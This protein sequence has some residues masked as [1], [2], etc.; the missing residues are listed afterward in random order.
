MNVCFVQGDQSSTFVPKFKRHVCCAQERQLYTN[1]T[2][3]EET[4][5]TKSFSPDGHRQLLTTAST[6]TTPGKH[7]ANTCSSVTSVGLHFLNTSMAGVQLFTT[8]LLMTVAMVTI[9]SA[10]PSGHKPLD[11]L[12]QDSAARLVRRRRETRALPEVASG[13]N[14]GSILNGLIRMTRPADSEDP[15]PINNNGKRIVSPHATSI[16]GGSKPF[17]NRLYDPMH[18]LILS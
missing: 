12:S 11:T 7:L 4:S 5:R 16:F 9:A 6:C 8:L 1:S 14:S 17:P 3:L 2:T 15:E 10:L 18:P 13:I